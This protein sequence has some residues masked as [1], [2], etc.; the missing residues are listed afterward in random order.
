[1]KLHTRLFKSLFS[2][3][4]ISQFRFLGVGSTIIYVLSLTFLC[5]LPVFILFLANLFN[6]SSQQL[7][8]FQSYGLNP[9]QMQEFASSINGVLPIIFI[10]VYAAMYILFSG[11][12]FSG[13]SILSGIGLQVSKLL[14]KKL[15]YRHIWVMACYTITLPMV[16]ITIL[17]LLNVHIPYSFFF[18]WVLTFIILVLAIT[19]IPAKK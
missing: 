10:V 5:I 9:D 2:I 18:F 1:M 14:N 17:F 6:N 16:L 15:S 3:T 8:N 19:R 13:V 11:I 12:L 4:S 7:K